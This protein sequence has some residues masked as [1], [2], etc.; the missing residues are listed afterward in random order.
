MMAAMM[1]GKAHPRFSEKEPEGIVN[2][3]DAAAKL[4]SDGK[5]RNQENAEMAKPIIKKRRRGRGAAKKE[6]VKTDNT[7]EVEE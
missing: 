7:A 6:E 1:G 5:M 2:T 3:E 4:I